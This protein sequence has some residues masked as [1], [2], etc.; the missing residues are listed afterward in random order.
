MLVDD[1]IM[2]SLQISNQCGVVSDS[3]SVSI[4]PRVPVF[5][6]ENPASICDGDTIDLDVT[7]VFPATYLWNAGETTSSIQALHAGHYMVEVGAPCVT[8]SHEFEIESAPDCIPFPEFYIPNAFS[9]NGDNI[10]DIFSISTLDQLD[11]LSMEGSIFDRWGNVL[12]N[13]TGIPFTW[14]GTFNKTELM[15]GVYVYFIKISFK[16]N[17]IVYDKTF[18][19]DVTLIR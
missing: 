2:Y 18:T 1:S 11:I 4:D 19:G 7:Q 16:V 14:D 13:S 17:E 8:S 9:P 15:S 10:N 3:L 12:F 5:E 6:M